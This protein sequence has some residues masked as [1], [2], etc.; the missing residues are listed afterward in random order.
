M[1][2]RKERRLA[3]LNAT[4]RRVKLDLFAEPSGDLGASSGNDEVDGGV[5]KSAGDTN[6]PSSSGKH[7]DNPLLLLGQYSDDELNDEEHKR[8]KHDVSESSSIEQK[9][10][11]PVSTGCEDAEEHADESDAL[12]T[13]LEELEKEFLSSEA[14]KDLDGD[15]VRESSASLSDEAEPT[16]QIPD[17]G[18]SLMQIS[19]D[20]SS[21]WKLVMHEESG[22]YYY[23]NTLTGETSWEVPGVFVQKAET[24]IGQKVPSGTEDGSAAIANV[25]TSIPVIVDST[26]HM[27]RAA[28]KYDN[29]HQLSCGGHENEDQEAQNL[30]LEVRHT[31]PRDSGVPTTSGHDEKDD[32]KRIANEHEAALSTR[33]VEYGKSLLERL[34]AVERSN[35]YHYQ[36]KDWILKYMLEIEIRLSDFRSLMDCESSLLPFWVHSEGKLQALEQAIGHEISQLTK[37]VQMSEVESGHITLA[38]MN[39]TLLHSEKDETEETAGYPT[40]HV[41]GSEV[42]MEKIK[43]TAHP[44]EF[45]LELKPDTDE[46]TNMDVDMEVDDEITATHT[47]FGDLSNGDHIAHPA[48][49]LV[50]CPHSEH[51]E[52][53]N[54]PP[55]DEDWIPAPPPDD[56]PIPPPPPDNE[57]IPP[58]PPDE[59][60]LS[61]TP[62]PP[63][64]ESVPPFSFTEHYNF[65]Y[66]VSGYG[67]YGPSVPPI[68]STNYYTHTEG[69]QI[70]VSQP[71]QCYGSVSNQ[72]S[73]CASIMVNPVE[74]IVYY[75]PSGTAPSI[76]S[77]I[78]P[79]N[80]YAGSGAS[81]YAHTAASDQSHQG[82]GK[83]EYSSLP[84]RNAELDVSSSRKSDIAA[85]QIPPCSA[86]VQ[87]AATVALKDDEPA[88]SATVTAPAA[89]ST[90]A[91]KAQTKVARSKKKT[92]AVATTLRSNKKVSSLV[93]KWK[94]AKEELHEDDEDEPENAYEMLEKKKQR[95]IEEWRARQIASGEA[96]DNANFQPLGGD[97]RERV[98]RKRALSK[99]E[100]VETAAAPTNGKQQ[101]DLVELSRDLPSGWQAYWDVSSKEVY[102][103]NTN[104]SETTWI[105]PTA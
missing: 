27:T 42:N 53:F 26:A 4:G 57:P 5:D 20:G 60:T 71:S 87:A 8:L 72:F 46:E 77:T 6:L 56:E 51:E 39:S 54:V 33:L 59:P 9:C 69:N 37:S 89:L 23:W 47:T 50:E 40:Q 94:A 15:D 100:A 28:E 19:G 103:G 58:P 93:D 52:G 62:H 102:Y 10:Q 61:Y 101:P 99:K 45:V 7:Q 104:T 63:Y 66:P 84:V 41:G 36:G 38:K 86:T 29:G 13:T 64:P 16:T 68:S 30:E 67:Y 95:E 105:R 74:P 18:S 25:Y 79:S 88:T 70:D 80:V 55:P 76:T 31:E 73:E 98:K 1:G 78:Q 44:T 65:S 11:E 12:Q 17:T 22:Q 82:S 49:P 83:S 96:K 3:A 43:E 75:D 91:S 2:K 48:S 81:N 14:P 35:D 92:V 24:A 97:W 21:S 90:A 34:K 85:L 32:H